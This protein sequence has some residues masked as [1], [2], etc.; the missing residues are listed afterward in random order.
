MTGQS[1][2]Q[3]EHWA[4]R[5]LFTNIWAHLHNTMHITTIAGQGGANFNNVLLSS[6]G[7]ALASQQTKSTRG[8]K[9]TSERVALMVLCALMATAA[10][11]IYDLDNF[12]TLQTLRDENEALK[13]NLTERLSET[14]PCTT[15]QPVSSKPP[16]VKERLSAT[17]P[18]TTVQPVSTKPPEVKE[19]SET[20]P[21]ITVPPV[22]PTPPEVKINDSC[23]RCETGWEQH[24]GQCYYFSTRRSSWNESRSFCQSEGGDLVKIDRREKQSLL[25]KT[26]RDKM[27][28]VEDLFWIGLTDSKTE[29]EWLW[30]DDSPLNTSLS[31]WMSWEPDNWRGEDPDGENCARMGVRGGATDLKCWNDISCKANE[32]YICEKQAENGRWSCI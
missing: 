30:V 29:G 15:V 19:R 7:E 13:R 5:G 28:H 10:I 16:E 27:D 12:L 4:P 31:F 1:I 23:V 3:N 6:T 21:C 17:K 2:T 26:V 14:K 22:C 11:V 9:F 24:G 32:K 18:H 20:K 25:E 8:S